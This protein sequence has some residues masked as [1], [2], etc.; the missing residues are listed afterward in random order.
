[1]KNVLGFINNS[2]VNSNS[3]F[4]KI[5][6]CFL[7]PSR[8]VFGGKK[9]VLL[10]KGDQKFRYENPRSK[11]PKWVKIALRILAVPGLILV[12]LGLLFKG[13]SLINI[14]TRHAYSDWTKPVVCS[15]H[16]DDL[17]NLYE[18]CEQ[19]GFFKELFFE[20]V[21]HP[22]RYLNRSYGPSG[23][24]HYKF[25]P[26]EFTECACDT[27]AFD[28]QKSPRR[29][30][31]ENQIIA[32]MK[33][34]KP[35]K[36]Q[37]IHLLSMG[38]GGL[39]QDWIIMGRLFKA[40]YKNIN[41]ALVDPKI[42]AEKFNQFTDFFKK[43]KIGY[44]RISSH[45]SVEQLKDQEPNM[46]FD[47]VIAIDF[48]DFLGLQLIKKGEYRYGCEDIVTAQGMLRDSGRLYLGWG[49][50]D[51][52]IDAN[53]KIETLGK[54]GIHAVIS[55]DIQKTNKRVVI[56]A[57]QCKIALLMLLPVVTKLIEKGTKKNELTLVGKDDVHGFYPNVK[58][59]EKVLKGFAPDGVKIVV[60]HLSN[61]D[62][63]L[64]SEKQFDYLV[65]GCFEGIA[66]Q[67]DDIKSLL[68]ENGVVYMLA[69]GSAVEKITKS[70]KTRLISL[71]LD[72][73]R[74]T[75][76]CLCWRHRQSLW[77]GIFLL[78]LLDN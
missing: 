74:I 22:V 45:V 56:A 75:S 37:P 17:K 24:P 61:E 36:D 78:G 10:K 31:L 53:N 64:K 69:K 1:M 44:V 67:L 70:G 51:F 14:Q 49:T 40:G 71:F 21:S 58:A 5:G 42:D 12:P 43:L 52:V 29:V 28:R 19:N 35:D 27:Q 11:K 4:E 60:N 46:T 13:I 30:R 54:P 77:E 2:H 57:S 68:T 62:E 8:I 20:V 18:T 39:L 72:H 6:D 50:E 3:Y 38:C 34:S 76:H 59:V 33:K 15:K 23:V 65:T 41:I 9:F 48:D 26:L 7:T 32:D 63:F 55:K 16:K 25:E 66:H 47:A 73:Q